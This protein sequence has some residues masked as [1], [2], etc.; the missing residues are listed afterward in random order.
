[1]TLAGLLI[2]SSSPFRRLIIVDA[3]S[4]P[5][6]R[7]GHIRGAM[8]AQSIDDLQPLF[9][10]IGGDDIGIVFHCE[11]SSKRAPFLAFQFRDYD[12][13]VQGASKY[14]Q[15]HF[16]Q[17]YL[18]DRGYRLFYRRFAHL[19]QGGY[20]KMK[21]IS[22]RRAFPRSLSQEG[23]VL[24]LPNF[25]VGLRDVCKLTVSQVQ[26]DLFEGTLGDIEQFDLLNIH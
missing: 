22:P 13:K 6:Y 14:P 11:Y 10:D 16:P 25:P 12:R 18:L 8:N 24:P 1:M 26:D 2:D 19:C 23:P 4:N 17:V 7:A 20:L 3:R 21:M 9:D 5:E 15:L